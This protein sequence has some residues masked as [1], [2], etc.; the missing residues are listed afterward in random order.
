MHNSPKSLFNLLHWQGN[1][2]YE[3]LHR[4]C[5]GIVAEMHGVIKAGGITISNPADD[6]LDYFAQILYYLSADGAMIAAEEG[7]CSFQ[8]LF[9]CPWCMGPKD[10]LASEIAWPKKT[11]AYLCNAS[12]MPDRMGGPDTPFKPFVCPIPS[13]KK[14]FK[15]Q[16]QVDNEAEFEG[17]EAKDFK[18]SHDQMH[19]LD[20]IFPLEPCYQIIPCTLHYLMGCTKHIWSLGIA[21]YIEAE[22]VGTEVTGALK[23]KCGVCLN[24]TKVSNGSH[25][26]AARMVSIGGEQA[27]SVVGHFELFAKLVFRYPDDF[28]KDNPPLQVPDLQ[29]VGEFK[30]VTA[31]DL[32][33][34]K[35]VVRVGDAL[36]LLWNCISTRMH[37]RVDGNGHRLPATAEERKT[38]ADQL[39]RC[40]KMYRLAYTMA[41]GASAFKPYTHIGMHLHEFQRV[42]QYDLKD[43]SS[44]AQEHS[45]KMVK[46]AIG[47]HSN[48][49]LSVPDKLG[50]VG[51]SYLEQ[52]SKQIETKLHVEDKYDHVVAKQYEMKRRRSKDQVLQRVVKQE[53]WNTNVCVN[54]LSE[55]CGVIVGLRHE[56]RNKAAEIEDC[57][58]LV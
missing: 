5:N 28:D 46:T 33:S 34:F 32:Q 24:V 14:R 30:A 29:N 47:V 6:D 48:K 3:N 17:Q 16:A 56:E 19:K 31:H 15:T 12:H 53:R 10:S 44:E 26:K 37:G 39:Q 7:A 4:Q 52:G 35:N 42:L 18:K 43:Y 22:S 49:R 9:P 38:K 1:D 58:E 23:R 54:S 57:C 25:A 41:F 36:L 21:N 11:Y 45:G 27:R 51:A 8:G 2:H 20:P 50:R 55:T 40:E 13:C